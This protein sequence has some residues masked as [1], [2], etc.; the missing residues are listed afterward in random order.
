[1][2]VSGLCLFGKCVIENCLCVVCLLCVCVCVC[3]LKKVVYCCV[4]CAVRGL[5]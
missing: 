5:F 2:F 1:M 3:V 4:S